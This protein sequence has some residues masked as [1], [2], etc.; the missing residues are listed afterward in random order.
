MSASKWGLIAVAVITVVVALW[1]LVYVKT[2][3]Q[4]DARAYINDLFEGHSSAVVSHWGDEELEKLGWDKAA[5]QRFYEKELKERYKQFRVTNIRVT[6]GRTGSQFE[7]KVD[8]ASS[9]G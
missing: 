5:A 9:G 7:C 6:P 1:K 3:R 4:E 8:L 2:S